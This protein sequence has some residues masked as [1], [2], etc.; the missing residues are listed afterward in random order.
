M[1]KRTFKAGN[2]AATLK[3][4][5]TGP[6]IVKISGRSGYYIRWYERRYDIKPVDLVA[7]TRHGLELEEND[8]EGLTVTKEPGQGQF[9]EG[10]FQVG[11]VILEVA[12]TK[13]ASLEDLNRVLSTFDGRRVRFRVNRGGKRGTIPRFMKAGDT[14]ERANASLAKWQERKEDR[15]QGKS[16]ASTTFRQ[17]ADEYLDWARTSGGYSPNWLAQVTDYMGRF[18]KIWGATTL[19]QIDTA[20]IEQ[21][22]VAR[23]KDVSAVTAKLELAPLR[24]AFRL[25][26]KWKYV[27]KNPLVGLTIRKAAKKMPKYLTEP[28]AQTLIEIATRKDH[29]RLQPGISPKGG[30]PIAPAGG[31]DK[32]KQYYNADGTFDAAR[33]RF[34]MLTALRKSQLT[35]LRWSQYDEKQGTLTFQTDDGHREK[36]RRVHV[37]PLPD[38]AKTVI[39]GQPRLTKFIFPNL[40]GKHDTHIHSRFLPIAKAFQESTGRKLHIHMLRHTALTHLLKH[41]QNIAAVSKYAG[42]ADI[43][44]TEIY[45]HVLDQQL[46]EI[47]KNFD[48]ISAPAQAEATQPAT[49]PETNPESPASPPSNGP[50]AGT[51]QVAK[52]TVASVPGAAGD[53]PVTK[54]KPK[55]NASSNDGEVT[56]D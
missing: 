18:T 22:A 4:G 26:V 32:M 7:S 33:I 51:A 44:T 28:E 43:K 17:L 16:G 36:G 50:E 14:K 38:A 54:K 8:G 10:D 35:D 6:R 27:D 52:R 48:V 39:A 5:K 21:W 3:K 29:E 9:G 40:L 53:R 55:P 11:D 20:K 34:F 37:I 12:G 30:Q 41:S 31:P 15:K 23:Q 46:K 45:A 2:T 25:A 56:F 1:S 47:T 49:T 24:V 19:D 42:H 13:V